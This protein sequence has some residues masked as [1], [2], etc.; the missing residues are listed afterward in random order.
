M[1]FELFDLLDDVSSIFDEEVLFCMEFGSMK[2]HSM[3][4]NRGSSSMCSNQGLVSI[5]SEPEQS[6]LSSSLGT[7]STVQKSS[8]SVEKEE[9]FEEAE[10]L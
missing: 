7:S 5:G 10:A 2:R 4:S 8:K 3:C 6:S 9:D 1:L